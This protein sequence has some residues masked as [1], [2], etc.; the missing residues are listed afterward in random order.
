MNNVKR[1]CVAVA[2]TFVL[3][4]S[5]LAQ[6]PPPCTPGEVNSPPCPSDSLT[7]DDSADPEETSSVSV[8][9]LADAVF[10]VTSELLLSAIF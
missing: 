4:L 6:T 9:T 3:G 5:T 10:E 2:L 7:F 1:L 8:T